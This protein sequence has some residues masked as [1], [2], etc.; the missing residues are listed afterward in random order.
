MYSVIPL[1]GPDFYS[2]AY[3]I[4]P[5]YKIDNEPL[6]LKIIRS[7]A[8]YKQNL[9]ESHNII[10][11]LR[12]TKGCAEVETLLKDNFKGCRIVK[13]S[14]LTIGALFSCLSACSLIKNFNSPIIFDLA[15]IFFDSEFNIAGIFSDKNIGAILPVFKSD[16]EK[17]SYAALNDK[18]EVLKTREKIVI[19][20]NASAGVY[21]FNN[22]KTYLSA[23]VDSIENFSEYSFKDSLFL[24][25]AMNGV[26]KAGLKVKAE[27][28]SNINPV[29]LVFK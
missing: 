4:R 1:A 19:S 7:R 16:N 22:I 18:A 23:V 24:C 26:I 28:V 12:D 3:G 25:P 13:L 29:S 2:D 11:V 9:V 27:F 20:Y 21:I 10:F 15:D 8:W 6:I 17:Y 14:D 5:L